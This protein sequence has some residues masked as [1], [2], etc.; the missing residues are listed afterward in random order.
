MCCDVLS[1]LQNMNMLLCLT[2]R[3]SITSRR[4]LDLNSPPKTITSADSRKTTQYQFEPITPDKTNGVGQHESATKNSSTDEAP[5]GEKSEITRNE[6]TQLHEKKAQPPLVNDQLCEVTSTQLQENHKPDKGGTEEADLLK[7]PQQKTRRRKHRPKVIIEGKKK[8]TPES[9]AQKTSVPQE[10]TRIKRKYVRK[11]GVNNPL[12]GGTNGIE[13]DNQTPSSIE[14]PVGKRKYSRRKGTSKSDNESDDESIEIIEIQPPRQTRR[15]CRR[16]LNFNLDEQS[17]DQISSTCESSHGKKEL[18]VENFNRED[19][20]ETSQHSENPVPPT[21][22]DQ[23]KK[24][25]MLTEQSVS[26]RGKCQL[27]FSD[28]THDKEA[29]TDQV[30]IEPEGQWKPR[31]SSDSISSGAQNMDKSVEGPEL[32]KRN[33]SGMSYN[34][35]QAYLSVFAPNADNGATG[36]YFPPICKK[37][38]SEKASTVASNLQIH[39]DSSRYMFLCPTIQGSYGAQR[40]VNNMQTAKYATLGTQNGKQVFEDLLAL[41]PTQRAKRRRS[42]GPIRHRN[43]ASLMESCKQWPCSPGRTATNS[44]NT[45]N[46]EILNEPLTCI[47]ALVADTRSTVATKKRSK[48]TMLIN[49]PVQNVYNQQGTVHDNTINTITLP[50]D[51]FG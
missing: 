20:P 6:I 19:Q 41:G 12:A 7:T 48:R 27:V 23:L 10:T 17:R 18:Q 38:R 32:C 30:S 2:D 5:T 33:E 11:N 15:S 21:N 42:K 46:I 16:S 40:N 22:K 31:S 34:S 1:P 50:L 14:S 28:V 36:F 24:N 49:S 43:V 35:L 3:D 45:Q 51:C 47:E 8:K 13:P 29:T 4:F 37:K 39:R 44:R 9:S 26:T 25:H